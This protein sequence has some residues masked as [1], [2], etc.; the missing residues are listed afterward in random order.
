[1]DNP[2]QQNVIISSVVIETSISKTN[3]YYCIIPQ[4]IHEG[5]LN[6]H[7]IHMGC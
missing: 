4:V 5:K 2:E 1:M 6:E 3:Q 7:Y